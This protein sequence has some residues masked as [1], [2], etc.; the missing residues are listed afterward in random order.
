MAKI[1][2]KAIGLAFYHHYIQAVQQL[3]EELYNGFDIKTFLNLSGQFVQLSQAFA[4]NYGSYAGS[5]LR[6]L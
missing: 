6:I 1:T 2:L 5:N 4:S 3:T